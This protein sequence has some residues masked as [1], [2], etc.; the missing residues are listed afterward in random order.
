M[1]KP[2]PTPRPLRTLPERAFRARARLVAVLMCCICFAGLAARLL[3]LQLFSGGWYTDRALGQQLRDT[4]VPAD[5]GR[6]Y[7]ADGVLLAA[8]SSCWTL[9]ASPREMPADKLELAAKGLAEILELD[10]AKLLE[11]FS[12]RAS[13]DC[14][15]RYRVERDTA[16]AVRDFCEANGITGIRINQDSKRWYPQGEFLASVLGFTN[17]DNAGVSGLEL[18]YNDVLTGDN[19]VV[20]TAVN[21]WGY[22]LEQSYETEKVPLEGS[23]L[24][25]TIDAN[26]QHYLENALDY[27]VKEHH[28]SARAVGIV[29]D[30]N[31]GAVL[32]MS[33]TPAYDPNEPRVIYDSAARSAVDALTGDARA[34]ALQLAQQT[35][36]RNKA[37]SDL[38]EPGSVFKLITCAAALDTGAV[39][40][41]STF[42]CGESI[43]VAGTRFHCANH[44]RHGS[45]TVTQALENSCNQSFIQIGARLGKEAFCDYFAAFGLREPTGIDLPA[46]PKKSLYYTA[47]RMGPVELAS[48]AFGQSSKISYMEMAAAVC[49]V[50]N[51]GKLMQPYLV[52][53]ILNPDGSVLQHID[54]VCRRQVIRP[55]TSRIMRGMME[56]VVQNGGGRYAQIRGYR[57]GGKS[58]TSQKL[59][60]ADEKAR[61][62]SFVAV[63]PI[64]DPQFL[65]LVCLDEPHSWT[66]AGGS[67]SAPVCAEVLEQTL[68]YRGV[69]RAAEPEAD[70]GPAQTAADLPADGDS[71]DGA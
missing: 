32:A 45:Q 66:T 69:P 54:P 19:G 24:R 23:G 10:E 2:E 65:C 47:D 44:K 57:V 4:V 59:D 52:S 58:G 13:N 6:I 43:S 5:R 36:W 55:E 37:V 34:A 7:S 30:V 63:A 42:Y 28:V 8:N 33:T 22:T 48:C 51:G 41:H 16:D 26:I 18:K 25:L 53:D 62:A 38:Y 12:D 17:V 71:F 64:D 35:Q 68:V 56:A 70:A 61:I 15:L 21:A 27:A 31:T 40:K 39:S 11:K 50:V 60:S 3:Y 14:L 49:A 20:L 9:R 29:M 67:L 1:P 46:E